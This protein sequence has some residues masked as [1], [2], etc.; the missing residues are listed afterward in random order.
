MTRGHICPLVPFK[1][2]FKIGM[3][4]DIQGMKQPNRRN[5]ACYNKMKNGEGISPKDAQVIK[6][7]V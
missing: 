7:G 3:S 1:Y 2:I 5:E 4:Y 6:E